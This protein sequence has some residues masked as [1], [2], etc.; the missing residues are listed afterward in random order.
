MDDGT[1]LAKLATVAAALSSRTRPQQRGGTQVH[2]A[3]GLLG[4]PGETEREI[5]DQIALD[6]ARLKA[7]VWHTDH[8]GEW[9]SPRLRPH[10]RRSIDADG[11]D[12]EVKWNVIG[13]LVFF[14]ALGL[15]AHIGWNLV[16]RL[17]G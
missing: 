7:N 16:W 17:L 3:R 11:G 13:W 14:A 2:S 5:Q 9:Q 12:D 4:I 8:A 1:L 15:L 10:H 6:R